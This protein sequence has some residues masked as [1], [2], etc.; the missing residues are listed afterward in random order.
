M[1]T[2]SFLALLNDPDLLNLSQDTK[3][4]LES[5]KLGDLE[6]TKLLKAYI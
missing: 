3:S 6:I 5:R 1:L 4:I 2:S